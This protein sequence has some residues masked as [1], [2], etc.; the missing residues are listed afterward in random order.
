[1]IDVSGGLATADAIQGSE[2]VVIEGMDH[3]LPP[4]LWPRI[5]SLIANLVQRVEAG[6]SSD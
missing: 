5:A 2:L 1:M 3:N 6:T 4:A